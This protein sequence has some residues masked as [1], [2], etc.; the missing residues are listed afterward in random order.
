V[1]RGT[2][3]D[4]PGTPFPALTV[5]KPERHDNECITATIVFYYVCA[6]GVP[7]EADVAKAINDLENMYRALENGN[8]ADANF[9]FMKSELTVKDAGGIQNKLAT[10][11]PPKPSGVVG[12]D[13]FPESTRAD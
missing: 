1:S 13:C 12:Y 10:Q 2:A 5:Q 11:P 6:G 8:L 4:P 9:D 7:S 3:V